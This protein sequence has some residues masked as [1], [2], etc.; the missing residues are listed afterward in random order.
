MAA[1]FSLPALSAPTGL[2]CGA[3][4]RGHRQTE[5]LVP[6]PR[7]WRRSQ[8]RLPESW[9]LST[10]NLALLHA[11]ETDPRRPYPSFR[12]HSDLPHRVQQLGEMLGR[13]HTDIFVLNEIGAEWVLHAINR[14][15]LH[16]M[17]EVIVPPYMEGRP[18]VAFMVQKNL[19]LRT[20]SRLLDAISWRDPMAGGRDT[21]L[22]RGGLG[23]LRIYRDGGDQL[24]A[25][26]LG[27]HL[28]SMRDRSGDPRSETLRAAQRQ[29]LQQLIS[30][31]RRQTARMEFPVPIILA[32]DFNHD[33]AEP[34]PGFENLRNVFDL[35]LQGKPNEDH[36]THI[37]FSNSGEEVRTQLDGILL[38]NNSDLAVQ[39]AFV[40]RELSPTGIPLP[41]PS[42]MEERLR[43]ASDHLPV[44][45]R[46]RF[47]R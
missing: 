16:S 35:A 31:L 3:L 14:F 39:R 18:D 22:F 25:I 15:Y 24:D 32:G 42:S 9:T 10:Y 21:S 47:L 33:L 7:A 30:S 6:A 26:V 29:G 27:V 5:P 13:L 38:S 28:K 12:H 40:M 41:W 4:F 36:D 2:Q 11:P 23:I 43:R 45:V 19:R 37:S 34:H 8:G 20:T 44:W 1:A 46:F 17:Y